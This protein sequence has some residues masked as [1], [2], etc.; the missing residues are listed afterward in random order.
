MHFEEREGCD[1][2]AC[3]NVTLSIVK[4]RDRFAL[5]GVVKM[6]ILTQPVVGICRYLKLTREY[7]CYTVLCLFMFLRIAMHSIK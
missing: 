4:K 3:Y 1:S 2:N 6:D 7:K 5:W